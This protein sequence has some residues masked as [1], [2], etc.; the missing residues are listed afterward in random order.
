[1]V[2]RTMPAARRIKSSILP[3]HRRNR[4]RRR[5]RGTGQADGA[6]QA[7][8]ALSTHRGG[9]RLWAARAGIRTMRVQRPRPCQR[10]S[11][12]RRK[13]CLEQ[14]ERGPGGIPNHPFMSTST[15]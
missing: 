6:T 14:R 11:V 12:G 7:G 1:M 2:M 5:L 13:C 3:G 15:A 9:A 4:S 8:R 10:G